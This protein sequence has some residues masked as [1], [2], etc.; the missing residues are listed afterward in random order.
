MVC[1]EPNF[2]AF[3]TK[4]PSPEGAKYISTGCSPVYSF[5]RSSVHSFIRSFVHPFIRSFVHPFICS[6]VHPFIHSSIHSF[7][8]T[9]TGATRY[10][11]EYSCIRG[12]THPT[13]AL[14][15]GR[16]LMQAI[17]SGFLILWAVW[18]ETAVL[19]RVGP[20]TL[21][22]SEMELIGL[23]YLTALVNLFDIKSNRLSI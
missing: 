1:L 21:V 2:S 19:S 8:C 4:P 7:I 20:S 3:H 22:Q 9:H 16:G 11:Q 5:I 10:N 14:W 15:L 18:I 6:F 23:T 12:Y 13:W 17:F